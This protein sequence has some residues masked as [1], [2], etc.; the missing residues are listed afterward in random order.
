MLLLA[1]LACGP[2]NE[3]VLDQILETHLPKEIEQNDDGSITAKMA[4]G[5]TVDIQQGPAA[6]VPADFPLPV[7]PGCVLKSVIERPP[8]VTVACSVPVDLPTDKVLAFYKAN[9][10]SRGV[11]PLQQFVKGP[12]STDI[13]QASLDG[14]TVSVALHGGDATR[15]LILSAQ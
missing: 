15:E 14:R 4:D 5:S 3:D 7:V 6:R 12:P 10:E 2:S 8:G 13:L 1:L 11:K 9:F